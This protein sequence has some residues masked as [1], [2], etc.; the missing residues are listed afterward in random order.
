[1]SPSPVSSTPILRAALRWGAGVCA[2]VV[3]LAGLVGWMIGQ[4]PGLW[5]GVLGALVGAVFPA[6]TAATILFANRWFGTP[7]YPVVFFGVFL[8]GWLLKFIVFVIVLFVLF[9]Q[10]WAVQT[11]LYGALVAAVLASFVVD[12]VVIWRMRIPAVSDPAP[13]PSDES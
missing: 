5:S 7:N 6:L 1:M 13:R 12:V 10:A 8:G 4:A 11:V 2:A 3:V 9:G